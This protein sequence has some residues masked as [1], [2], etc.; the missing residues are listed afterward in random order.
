MDRVKKSL[1]ILVLV[2]VVSRELDILNPSQIHFGAISDLP[3]IHF[4]AISN[5]SRIYL[6]DISNSPRKHD[7]FTLEASQTFLRTWV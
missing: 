7:I 4:G 5:P 2:H 6:R 1:L 3:Q